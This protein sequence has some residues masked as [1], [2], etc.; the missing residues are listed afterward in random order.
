ML[1]KSEKELR[2]QK[3][4]FGQIFQNPK[5]SLVRAFGDVEATAFNYFKHVAWP[6][7]GEV[8]TLKEKKIA[9]A[10]LALM[11][12]EEIGF[13]CDEGKQKYKSKFFGECTANAGDAVKL[14]RVLKSTWKHYGSFYAPKKGAEQ[15]WHKQNKLN[16]TE[17]RELVKMDDIKNT[18]LLDEKCEDPAGLLDFL[19]AGEKEIRREICDQII[20]PWFGD[21]V[22][23]K[24]LCLFEVKD[25]SN[26]LRLNTYLQ[27]LEIPLWNNRNT[28]WT[29]CSNYGI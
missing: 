27:V 13:D 8:K 21:W 26:Y 14:K 7:E 2:E 6:D 11:S 4:T 28:F 10:I 20:R 1:S 18:S 12:G 17:S 29:K 24:R 15:Q 16:S 22:P 3:W 23:D 5:L 25:F 19:L 9:I